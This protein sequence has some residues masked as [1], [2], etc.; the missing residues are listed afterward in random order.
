MAPTVSYFGLGGNTT[1][2]GLLGGLG[3]TYV[4]QNNGPDEGFKPTAFLSVIVRGGNF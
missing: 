4:T 2:V 1:S 3:M